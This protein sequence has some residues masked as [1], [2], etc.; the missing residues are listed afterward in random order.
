MR[1]LEIIISENEFCKSI[2]FNTR[3]SQLFNLKTN[4]PIYQLLQGQYFWWS[5]PK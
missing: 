2:V 5:V 4:L 3:Y 1:D